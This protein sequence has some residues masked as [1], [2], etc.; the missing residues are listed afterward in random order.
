MLN[1]CGIT[2]EAAVH[3]RAPI[4]VEALLMSQLAEAEARRED[5]PEDTPIIPNPDNTAAPP[6]VDDLPVE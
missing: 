4:E 3:E 1:R 6:W 2:L 5:R